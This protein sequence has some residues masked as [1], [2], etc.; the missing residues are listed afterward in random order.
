MSAPTW[1]DFAEL[2]LKCITSSGAEYGD[3]RIVHSISQTI[4]GEDRRIASIRDND[5]DVFI[6]AKQGLG[7]GEAIA[8]RARTYCDRHRIARPYKKN[9]QAS[10]ES[11]NRTLPKECFGWGTYRV[12][13]LP[14]LI[15]AVHMLL[16]RYHYHRPHLGLSPL[17]PPLQAPSTT[18]EDRQSDIYGE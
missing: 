11:F 3:S 9:E 15:P 1:D 8:R 10:I 13:D 5:N 18:Q 16:D 17:R 6:Q 4:R 2:A 12:E 7:I 14:Q